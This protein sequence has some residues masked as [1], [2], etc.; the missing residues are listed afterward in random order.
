MR[1]YRRAK[2]LTLLLSLFF[3][4]IAAAEVVDI[5]LVYDT[6]ATSWVNSNGGMAVFSQDAVT[7]MNQAMQNSGIS[8][9][10]RL[11]HSMSV[12]YTTTSNGSTPFYDDLNALEAGTGGFAAVHTAR[13]TYKADLVAMLVDTGS[14]YGYVGLG[15]LLTAWTGV[16]NSCF[17]VNAIQSVN[18]SQTLTH[19]V[20]HNLGAHHSKNQS[21]SPGPNIYLDNQY[22]AG[23]YFTGTNSYDYHTV[24]AYNNDGYGNSYIPAL[25]PW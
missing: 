5:M 9:S 3:A 23:W 10:F 4:N 21:A 2:I 11:A 25:V 12:N 20:G 16:P 15:D 17:T 13:E 7:R 14:A 1:K 24:M 6:T 8:H 18:I 22:S 19:E